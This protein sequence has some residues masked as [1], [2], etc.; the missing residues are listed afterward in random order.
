M[1]V[2]SFFFSSVT[3]LVLLFCLRWCLHS[4]VVASYFSR[5]SKSHQT[6]V[7]FILEFYELPPS[8]DTIFSF[9]TSKE[10]E[11]KKRQKGQT[12]VKIGYSLS[13]ATIVIIIHLVFA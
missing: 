10:A 3:I 11:A 9:A 6:Q 2:L 7:A 12:N 8:I 1:L 13:L 5:S 4:F